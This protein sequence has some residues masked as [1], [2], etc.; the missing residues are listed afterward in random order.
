MR[1][2]DK[3]RLFVG[4]PREESE[5]VE[6]D[7]KTL[8]KLGCDAEA[9]GKKSGNFLIHLLTGVFCSIYETTST[10]WV[11]GGRTHFSCGALF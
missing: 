7:H 5:I 1:S 4:G 2:K 3:T 9:K 11:K 10:A 6:L 8:E